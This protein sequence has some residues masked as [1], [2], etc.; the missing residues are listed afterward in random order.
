M[1]A[2][3]LNDT[4]KAIARE[5]IILRRTAAEMLSALYSIR[6]ICGG[7]IETHFSYNV[8]KQINKAIRNG[9]KL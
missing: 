4:T 5:N 7:E 8:A 6:D 3:E 9:E 1:I 2:E